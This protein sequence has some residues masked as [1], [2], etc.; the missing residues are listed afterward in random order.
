MSNT[1]YLL[2]NGVVMV[3][4]NGNDSKD[5]PYISFDDYLVDIFNGC[6]ITQVD[7]YP[8]FNVLVGEM[9]TKEIKNLPREMY[10]KCMDGILKF[11]KQDNEK[12]KK[13]SISQSRRK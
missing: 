8:L 10:L 6:K 13:K 12:N 4:N 2:Q 5:K 3:T 11:I 7:P 9:I 1:I